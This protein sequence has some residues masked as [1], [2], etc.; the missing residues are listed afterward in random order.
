[1]NKPEQQLEAILRDRGLAW[2]VDMFAPSSMATTHYLDSLSSLEK[3]LKDRRLGTYSFSPE[4]L[5]RIVSASP[6]KA[7]AFLQA[8]VSIPST[9]ILC[10]AWRI[11]QGLEIESIKMEYDRLAKFTLHIVLRSPY[12]ETEEYSSDKIN[13]VVFVRHL[14]MSTVDTKPFFHG[15]FAL[16]QT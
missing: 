9:P 14:G 4:S 7:D 16:R 11:V 1:M 12:G 2:A 6:Y 10:A 3:Y 15:F 13:D 5:E 8:L